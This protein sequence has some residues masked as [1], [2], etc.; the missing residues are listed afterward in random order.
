MNV[1]GNCAKFGVEQAGVQSEVTGRSRVTA[2]LA[3]RAARGRSRDIYD[4]MQEE[5]VQD[6]SARVRDARVR[7]GMSV[8]ELALKLMETQS[9]LAKA[10]AGSYHPPDSLIGKLE[11]ELDIK[12]MEKPEAPADMGHQ[13]KGSKAGLTLGDLIKK[14]LEKQ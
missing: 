2:N 7:R 6:Y 11:K 4:S 14:E 5:L 8:E 10:E 9:T 3:Q 1:C 13:Q 12:L